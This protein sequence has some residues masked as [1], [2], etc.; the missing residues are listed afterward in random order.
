ML[1]LDASNC[2]KNA[3]I[4]EA[5]QH[6]RLDYHSRIVGLAPNHQPMVAHT[7]AAAP[8]MCCQPQD[9]GISRIS[10]RWKQVQQSYLELQ[11]TE[12]RRCEIFWIWFTFSIQDFQL[13]EANMHDWV[14]HQKARKHE[15][16]AFPNSF[17]QWIC[18]NAEP[19]HFTIMTSNRNKLQ[20]LKNRPKN[21]N[22]PHIC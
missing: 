8:A 14:N 3:S 5:K 18:L 7:H 12:A 10:M 6:T 16:H 11:Q 17:R 19:Q 21:P 13:H 1:D 15:L 9:E 22:I 20:I 2:H 4:F